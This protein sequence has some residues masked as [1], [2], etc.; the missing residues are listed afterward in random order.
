L[1]EDMEK[2]L[3]RSIAVIAVVALII[4]GLQELGIL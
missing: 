3:Y 4:T 1:I 2:F